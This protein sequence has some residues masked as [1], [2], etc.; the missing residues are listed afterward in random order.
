MLLGSM[1]KLFGKSPSRDY[2]GIDPS[3]FRMC[4]AIDVGCAAA[5]WTDEA[6]KYKD[7]EEK[8]DNE[9]GQIGEELDRHQ[10]SLQDR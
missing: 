7:S 4:T 10:K 3:E 8:A 2:L 9:A 6:Q 5:Y 1:G